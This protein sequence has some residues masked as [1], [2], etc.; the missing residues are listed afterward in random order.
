MNTFNTLLVL[1]GFVAFVQSA[2][3]TKEMQ[4]KFMVV[5]KECQ[6]QTGASD[7]DLANL[8]KH[9][10]TGTKEGKCMLSCIM[11]KVDTQDSNGKLKK[12]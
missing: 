5:A 1:V 3:I 12:E 10:P 8:I 4:E 9:N 11:T 2:S 7:A 6:G